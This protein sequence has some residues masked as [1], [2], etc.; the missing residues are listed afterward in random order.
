MPHNLNTLEQEIKALLEQDKVQQV[1]LLM[2]DYIRS[3]NQ[4][5]DSLYYLLGNAHRRMGD[6]P[7]AMNLYMEAIRLNP[8]SPAIY[9]L[10]SAKDVMAFYNEN[11]YNL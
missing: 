1:I 9:A 5:N 7:S 11:L 2:E 6:I 3:E 4:M 10:S 8:G